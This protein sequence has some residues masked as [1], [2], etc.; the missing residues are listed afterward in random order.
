RRVLQ[1]ATPDRGEVLK[2]VQISRLQGGVD[3]PLRI[4]EQRHVDEDLP[5]RRGLKKDFGLAPVPAIRR[6]GQRLVPWRRVPRRG[7]GR[8]DV[9]VNPL[10]VGLPWW[11]Q[12]NEQCLNAVLEQLP[13]L[14]RQLIDTGTT[15]LV[16][17]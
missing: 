4:E 16:G 1:D 10:W 2:G 3:I 8:P 13:D 9:T 17:R 12:V 11:E 5:Q 7:I 14:V 6:Q 15:I